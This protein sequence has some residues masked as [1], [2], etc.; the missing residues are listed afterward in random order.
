[1]AGDLLLVR[2]WDA[3]L[4]AAGR[5]EATRRAYRYAVLRFLAEACPE[6][7]DAV[8][9]RDVV[10]F[11][12]SLGNRAQSKRSYLHALRSL[13]TWAHERRLVTHNPAKLLKTKPPRR[14]PPVALEMEELIRLVYAAACRSERRAWAIILCF[15]LGTRRTELAHIAPSDVDPVSQTVLLRVTKGDRPRRVEIGPL[16][17]VAL[18]GLRP[19][20]NGTVLGGVNPQTVTAWASQAA[21]DAGLGEKVKR[22]PAH[23]LRASFATWLLNEG[24]PVQV[25]AE[26]LGHAEI[27][28]TT[29]YA[30]TMRGQK[31]DAVQRLPGVAPT[32]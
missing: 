21:K 10:T 32:A 11:L 27:A 26:L 23:I 3:Y 16:A 31:E 12:A 6:S 20:Y 18:E 7:L 19:W 8:T 1:M 5:S 17:S 9:E 15:A 4:A 30:A 14:P 25:V 2:E 28:T 29:R 24:V 22:R 13:F